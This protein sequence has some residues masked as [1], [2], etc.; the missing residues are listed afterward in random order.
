LIKIV[1][2]VLKPDEGT[3]RVLG[4][5]VPFGH[6]ER[7]IAGGLSTVYQDLSLVPALTV[8][9][10]LCLGERGVPFQTSRTKERR[11]RRVIDEYGLSDIGPRDLVEDL[12]FGQRQRLE[13]VR[14]L[15]R[16]PRLLLL[17]EPTS[18]LSQPEVEWLF[19]MLRRQRELGVATV[20]I[21]HR[22]SE[23]RGICDRV[24]VL[25]NGQNVG[26]QEAASVSDAEIVQM[27]LGRSLA[28]AF[29]ARP[30]QAAT[31]NSVP[32]L[33]VR[34]LSVESLLRGVSFSL[35]SGEV[36]GIAGLDGQGQRLL[37]GALAGT[38]RS[39][40]GEILRRGKSV[41]IGSPTASIAKGIAFIPADRA[42]EGLLMP[43]SV[44]QNMS[45]PVIGR[46]TR[47]GLIR[48]AAEKAA[49][50]EMASR[51][52]IGSDR[53]QTA[54]GNLSGGN[55]QKVLLGKW[56]MTGAEVILLDDPTQGVDVGTK[57]EIGVQIL[58]LAAEGRGVVLYSTDLGELA[59]LADRVLVFYQGRIAAELRRPLMTEEAILTAMTGHG[60]LASGAGAPVEVHS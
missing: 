35:A 36:L 11:A 27:M 50:V 57:Y 38:R 47:L 56:L 5:P 4:V 24:T 14:A 13:I 19:D 43:L 22:M 54:V 6:P 52:D 58:R 60:L 39:Q 55:Q 12:S 7:A 23:I 31:Q 44:G 26:T 29:P 46:F 41:R 18:A 10:N 16:K 3:A 2:G 21:S 37:L 42:R 15:Q 32:V 1:T 20:F 28:A 34:D 48:E 51:L 30:E 8:A 40:N 49:V 25:R 17:D 53:V 33:E 45:L 9:S 59:H